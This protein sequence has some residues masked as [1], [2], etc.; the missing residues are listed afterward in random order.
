MVFENK[1]SVNIYPSLIKIHPNRL[2]KLLCSKCSVEV[3]P[4]Y[5]IKR[6]S[7]PLYSRVP[8]LSA[9]VRNVCTYTLYITHM[10]ALDPCTLGKSIPRLC[11]YN[12]IESI[13]RTANGIKH[14]GHLFKYSE[15]PFS[16]F[17]P[18]Y[19]MCALKN[20]VF[21]V[22]FYR[23]YIEEPSLI[24]IKYIL[25]WPSESTLLKANQFF[26]FK[27]KMNGMMFVGNLS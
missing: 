14:K 8:S 10:A 7:S 25:K 3:S 11:I 16:P 9:I 2:H 12:Y 15:K 26:V 13:Y 23:I 22:P 1:Y 21:V 4:S 18:R 6:F 19:L 24:Y 5:H 17:F 27:W 20:N